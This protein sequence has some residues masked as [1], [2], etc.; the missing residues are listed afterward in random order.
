[1][2][3]RSGSA[4]SSRRLA[5]PLAAGALAAALVLAPPALGAWGGGPQIGKVVEGKFLPGRPPAARFGDNPEE[6]CKDDTLARSLQDQ[7]EDLARR[8][9]TAVPR[10]DGRLC[11]AAE[12]F[13]G[14]DLREPPPREGVLA[15]VSSSVGLP[16]PVRRYQNVMI[17]TD[18]S[19]IL[20][21]K[22]LQPIGDFAV[23]AQAPRYGIAT[24][25]K[26]GSMRGPSEGSTRLVLL[27]LDI[28]Y[29]LDPLPRRL[30]PGEKAVISGKV[31][32]EY[33]NPKVTVS[34]V[35]GKVSSPPA[36]PGTA[37]QA[38]VACGDKPGRI[39]LELAAELGGSPT[40]VAR[41]PVACGTELPT[42]VPVAKPSPWPAETAQQEKRM[43]EALNAERT[44]VGIPAL[45]WDEPVAGVARG[46]SEAIRDEVRRGSY[47]VPGDVVQRLKSVGV[48]SPLVLQNPSQARSAEE[49][50]EQLLSSP[51]HRAS[52]M[53]PD[54][55]RAGVGIV[56]ETGKEGASS[57]FV[58]QLFI[59]QL[60][61][62]DPAEVRK[63][64]R[65]AVERKRRDARQSPV[66]FDPTLDGVAEKY[67]QELA[68]AGG[69]LAPERK[70]ALTAP[71]NKG[72]KTV[73][74]LAGARADPLDFAEEPEVVSAGKFAGVGVAIGMHP[75]LG[76]NAVY[77]V[78][79]VGS[80]R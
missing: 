33:R 15:F 41:F 46:I 65:D 23:G 61:P 20:A 76:R 64:L 69:T 32:G 77:A 80:K 2:T 54:V 52:I 22:L 72:F 29:S 78:I 44:A 17:A 71:L 55:N 35:M 56:P 62:L 51:G 37:F 30:A 25:R 36:T 16:V 8:S 4:R 59:K 5:R 42:S 48:A 24:Q 40:L 45:A 31:L 57:V 47:D 11:A 49:A 26:G 50:L 3:T 58:T 21:E 67:A 1:M 70:T 63:K 12:S 75:T 60:P 73:Q 14:W 9:K 68:Q 13:L 28:P 79:V 19:R 66:T 7:L 6:T 27:L 18:D 43:F 74:V 53:N 39:Q 38:E 34:D 10:P